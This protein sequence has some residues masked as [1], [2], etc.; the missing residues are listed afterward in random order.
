MQAVPAGPVPRDCPTEVAAVGL[1]VRVGGSRQEHKQS[2][3]VTS[4]AI[5]RLKQLPE[6]REKE[7]KAPDT[8][9]PWSNSWTPL[10]MRD[11]RFQNLED[12]RACHVS[13]DCPTEAAARGFRGR[14]ESSGQECYKRGNIWTPVEM[15]TEAAAGGS[16]GKAGGP[17]QEC[18]KLATSPVRALRMVVVAMAKLQ[19]HTVKDIAE[20]LEAREKNAAGV[21]KLATSPVR[22]L[23]TAVAATAKLQVYTVVD[24]A[25]GLEARDKNAT[26]WPHR[27]LVHSE[28]RWQLWWSPK[29]IPW[30]R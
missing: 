12:A 19:V 13:R 22:A 15:R 23:R 28:R 21:A 10:K 9:A 26:S 2:T 4:R 30:R 8:S 6:A 1:G 20:G 7:L 24:I 3:L 27:P 18:Y 17:G 11:R 29:W 5:T 14:T 16:G 25:E